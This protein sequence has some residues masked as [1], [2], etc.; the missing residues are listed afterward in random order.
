MRQSGLRAFIQPR[1]DQNTF[2]GLPLTILT[3]VF[4]LL[5][6]VFGNV[7]EDVVNSDPIV[8][9]DTRIATL[10]ATDR[11]PALVKLFLWVTLLGKG[12]VVG[13]IAAA[14]CVLFL[15]WHRLHY[16]V[17]LLLTL[18]GAE[19]T[20]Q[21]IK[22]IVDRVRPGADLAYYI[23]TSFSFPS[24]HATLSSALY[25]FLIYALAR[26][27]ARPAQRAGIALTGLATIIAVGLSRMYLGVHFLSDVLGGYLVGLLWV[28][29]GVSLAEVLRSR[30]PGA[31]AS[32]TPPSRQRTALM[33][34]VLA[35]TVTF[36]VT[37]A[38]RYA[39]LRADG[40]LSPAAVAE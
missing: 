21:T 35:A 10:L 20:A 2:V 5:L 1:L 18:G 33:L 8:T 14:A 23:E 28:I 38:I 25:G 12:L 4:V 15:L 6:I 36:Y 29:V 26:E 30:Y 13:V 40:Q 9:L 19:A 24:G 16:A 27:A 22:R 11:S 31:I 17:S 34:I 32:G 3:A 37:L 39:P 7:L